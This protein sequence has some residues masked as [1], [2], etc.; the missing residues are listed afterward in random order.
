MTD[1]PASQRST[2]S[3]TAANGSYPQAVKHDALVQARAGLG[4]ALARYELALNRARNAEGATRTAALAHA[5][6][7]LEQATG[8]RRRV[9]ALQADRLADTAGSRELKGAQSVRQTPNATADPHRRNGI[10]TGRLPAQTC[11]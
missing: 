2:T 11:A 1:K 5:R 10:L 8:L 9:Q 4:V 6:L 7:E 3:V